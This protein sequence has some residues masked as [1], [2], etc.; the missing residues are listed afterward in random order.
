VHNIVVDENN[1][2]TKDYIVESGGGGSSAGASGEDVVCKLCTTH[3]VKP[4]SKGLQ[5]TTLQF[6]SLSL[7]LLE[8]SI[9]F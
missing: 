8:N 4:V 6:F 3:R 2:L 1:T 7:S 5:P 9:S